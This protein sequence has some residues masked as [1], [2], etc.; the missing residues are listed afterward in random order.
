ME[1]S[2]VVAPEG[3]KEVVLALAVFEVTDDAQLVSKVRTFVGDEVRGLGRDDLVD[4]AV[5]VASELAT[6]AMLHAAGIAAVRVS[7]VPD[8][9]RIEVHDRRQV[10]PRMGLGTPDAMT[11]RGLHL[12]AALSARWAA[13]PTEDGKMV[14]AE[15]SGPRPNTSAAV[16]EAVLLE[17]WD[18]DAW[19]EADASLVRHRVTLGEVPTPLLVSAKAHVDNLVREFT[20]AA[21]GAESGVTR[22]LPPHLASLV[23]TV[24]GRFAEARQEIKRQAIAAANQ[25]LSH[26][27]LELNLPADAADAGEQYLEALD[28]SDAYC[29]AARLLTLETPPQHRVFRYWYVG[30]LVAQLR[31]AAAG[32]PAPPIQTFEERILEELDHAAKAQRASERAARLYDVS[33]ALSRAATREAVARAV[34]EQGVAALSASGGGILLA[35]DAD[36]LIVPGTVGYDDDVVAR[37]QAERRDAELPAAVALRTGEPV[38]LESREERDRLFPELLNL[39]RGTASVCAVPL[40]IGDRRLGALRF[41][42]PEPRLFDEDERRFVLALAAQTAQA[43]DRTQLYELRMDFSRRLQLSLLPRQLAAPANVE[44]A[45]IYHSLGDG[46]E[47]G[48]D[49]YDTWPISDACWGLAIVD[50]SGTGPEAAALTAMVRFTLR[51]L[52]VADVNPASV[53]VKL[54][55]ALLGMDFMGNEG[56]LFCTAIFGV[57]LPGR[58]ST[59][60][61]AAGGHPPPLLRRSDGRVEDVP[62]GGSL[63]GVFED[64]EIA[65]RSV[66]LEPGD[67]LVLYTDGAIEARRDGVMFGIDGLKEAVA[68][69]PAGATPVADSI[70]QAVLAHT[71][72]VVSDDLAA[73]VIHATG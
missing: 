57:L 14:W 59:V 62:V 40:T 27:R 68:A 41:S 31:A 1:R 60:A 5:L 51:A 6:N 72:G 69:A 66:T 52:T 46:M 32:Q 10:P 44:A 28:E 19:A 48:G 54:N 64:A 65:S 4:D 17:L 2:L 61:L 49:I 12:V 24:V 18:D 47:L 43:L 34:L 13:E 45:A 37:L 70:E 38:W 25:G 42:F 16:P 21:R 36:R 33:A 11:G 53:L 56:E 29:R 22:A 8:G 30:Q 50:A 39:E 26:V 23:E 3:R 67:T 15:L 71:G 63:L 7:G 73:L 55:H 9:V 58:R 20:L 35:T